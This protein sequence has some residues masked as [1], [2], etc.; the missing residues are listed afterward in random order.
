MCCSVKKLD[1][2][3]WVFGT[4][5]LVIEKQ[6]QKKQNNDTADSNN[7]IS[8]VVISNFFY[9]KLYVYI[10]VSIYAHACDA[11]S[12]ELPQVEDGNQIKDF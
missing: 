4:F 3:I 2:P 10:F 9:F 1:S 12:C 8:F 11:G 5:L 6:H 7:S